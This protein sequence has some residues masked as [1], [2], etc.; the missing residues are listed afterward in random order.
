M[1][2]HSSPQ[3]GVA[4]PGSASACAPDQRS[5]RSL[6]AAAVADFGQQLLDRLIVAALF[7]YHLPQLAVD[8][9]H[10]KKREHREP[11]H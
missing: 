3:A 11:Y 4:A 9:R 1:G 10:T 7:E 2:K 6:A 5:T 8:Q